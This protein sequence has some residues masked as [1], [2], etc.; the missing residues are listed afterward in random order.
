[1]ARA[2]AYLDDDFD[3]WD[4]VEDLDG[5]SHYRVLSISPK[6]S[7]AD[8]K[9]AY[10]KQ[11]RIHH[12]DKGGDA[13]IFGAVQAAWEVLSDKD[14]RRTYDDWAKQL[15]YRYIPGITPKTDGGE[16]VLLD[17]FERLG[18]HCDPTTQLV[19]LCEVCGRPSTKVC[20]VCEIRFCDFCTRKQHWKGKFGLHWPV[21]NAPVMRE[22][23]AKKELEKKRI[24]DARRMLLED[25]NHREEH[26]LRDIRSFK[27]A[28]KVVYQKSDAMVT[29]DLKLAKFYMWAQTARYVYLSCYVPTGY[30]DKELRFLPSA[31]DVTLQPEDSPP[32]IQRLWARQLDVSVPI[33]T[34]QA[35][36][37]RMFTMAAAK[38][39]PGEH[40]PQVFRGD[41]AGARCLEPPYIL[42]E[43]EDEVVME[44]KVPFWIDKGDVVVDITEKAITVEVRNQ[45]QLQRTFWKVQE[46]KKGVVVPDECI[47]SLDEDTDDNGDDIKVL[48]ITLVKPDL[49]DDEVMW[50]K[51][52]RD[53]NRNQ[54]RSDGANRKGVR[55]FAD[56]ED[57]FS[58]EDILQALCFMEAGEAWVPAKPWEHYQYPFVQPRKSSQLHQL[59]MQAQRHIE[60]ML[61]EGD[62]EEDDA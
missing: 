35:P 21:V 23:L 40:W 28:A 41:S 24:E 2:Y 52:K 27:D 46:G 48:M 15:K 4:S 30:T 5:D 3:P 32:I 6:A 45:L 1:M 56:D 51:G 14:K 42:T 11:A 10:K 58:L 16:D 8:V 13:H 43:T 60:M 49:T 9:A 26:E 22:Q 39:V 37:K 62:S 31:S 34:W 57:T 38:G 12:P 55:F 44:I 25:P 50:K 33:E 59:G 61:A 47:W 19:V 29:Y 7:D 20:Y 18:M 54:R 17:E 53:D 36:D